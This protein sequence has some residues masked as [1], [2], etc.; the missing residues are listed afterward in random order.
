[1]GRIDGQ[2]WTYTVIR[3]LSHL[4]IRVE[5]TEEEL[6]A[7]HLV[8]E[9]NIYDHILPALQAAYSIFALRVVALQGFHGIEVLRGLPR[10]PNLFRP[11]LLAPLSALPPIGS[12][13]RKL[14]GAPHI[15]PSDRSPG[16]IGLGVVRGGGNKTRIS[17]AIPTTT[18]N[19]F[20]WPLPKTH[21][22]SLPS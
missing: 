18:A 16:P 21:P 17:A 9:L 1:M 12:S 15:S 5:H 11:Y 7:K 20:R 6:V 3:D 14:T 19:L 2:T 4:F 13:P 10:I 8:I 22:K